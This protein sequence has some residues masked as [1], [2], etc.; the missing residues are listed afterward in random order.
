M[1]DGNKKHFYYAPLWHNFLVETLTQ[2]MRQMNW[3]NELINWWTARWTDTKARVSLSLSQRLK[4]SREINLDRPFQKSQ[5]KNLSGLRCG[6]PHVLSKI[7]SGAKNIKRNY[8]N[9]VVRMLPFETSSL[10]ANNCSIEGAVFFL[11][12]FIRNWESVWNR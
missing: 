12:S 4:K 8:A 10:K 7:S 6:R 2:R 9:M 11:Y 5:I 3:S 1:Y